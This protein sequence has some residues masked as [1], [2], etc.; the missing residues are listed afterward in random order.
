M[1]SVIS[2]V[3]ARRKL[4][5]Y[6]RK[7]VRLWYKQYTNATVIRASAKTEVPRLVIPSHFGRTSAG[8]RPKQEKTYP[9]IYDRILYRDYLEP[10]TLSMVTVR[11]IIAYS[12]L[13]RVH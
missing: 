1:T 13:R 9:Q 8:Y 11:A 4:D 5:A 3:L 10:G 12:Q 6:L 2:E 7:P